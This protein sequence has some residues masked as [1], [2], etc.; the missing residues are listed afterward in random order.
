VYTVGDDLPA[1]SA[2]TRHGPS[3]RCLLVNSS[4]EC[5]AVPAHAWRDNIYPIRE[6]EQLV[7]ACSE[8]EVLG[9]HIDNI[10]FGGLEPYEPFRIA[11]D[12]TATA[13]QVR[14]AES[15]VN[16]RSLAPLFLC[17]TNLVGSH[18]ALDEASALVPHPHSVHARWLNYARETMA[19]R[20][21]R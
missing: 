19:P 9:L 15:L 18:S 20:T 2:I 16:S 6:I 8:L 13:Q 11:A 10:N 5:R 21:A 12:T 4:L 7:T 3:L 17:L 14:Y 1:I